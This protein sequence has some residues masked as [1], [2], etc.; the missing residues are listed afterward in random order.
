MMPKNLVVMMQYKAPRRERSAVV[1]EFCSSD[2]AV[3]CKFGSQHIFHFLQVL[4]ASNAY[5]SRN[6]LI[7]SVVIFL[8]LDR[9]AAVT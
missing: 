5:V 3:P 8:F 7:K 6:G 9:M 2:D 4:M 1:L